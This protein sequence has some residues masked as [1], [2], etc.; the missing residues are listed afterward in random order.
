MDQDQIGRLERLHRLR[1]AG[2]LTDDEFALEK[3]NILGGLSAIKNQPGR[4]LAWSVA[5]LTLAIAGGAGI[6]LGTKSN[7]DTIDNKTTKK[8][9]V[10]A[11]QSVPEAILQPVITESKSAR[12]TN[13]FLIATGHRGAFTESV[14]GET[15]TVTPLKIID[16]SFGPA[17]LIKR[18][19]SDGCHAC[20]GSIGVY[21]FKEDGPRKTLLA[22]FP[23][24][25]EGWGWGAAPQ[26]WSMTSD[27]TTNPAVYASGSYMGQGIIISSA[28]LTEL[29]PQGPRTSDPI[30]TGY[31][32]EG[33]IVDNEKPSCEVKGKIGS[34]VRAKSFK[35]YATGS[36][37]SIDTFEMK[38][39]QFKRRGALDW[40]MPCGA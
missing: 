26:S 38:N 11:V 34:I 20:T 36:R 14:E 19:I 40:G 5:G 28:T 4:K 33:S 30:N 25:V 22:S 10:S 6:W 8:H 18:E 13:A 35:V 9:P 23:K 17:L 32:D 1:E 21:Y 39:G 24:A 2:A 12:L 31:S 3:K 27:F 7:P 16:L 29:R 37:T 15:Q